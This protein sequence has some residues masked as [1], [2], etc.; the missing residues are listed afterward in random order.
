MKILEN[1]RTNFSKFPTKCV[2]RPNA[3]KSKA[4][5]VKFFGKICKNNA[6]VAIFLRNF[7]KIF[8]NV[9]KIS[10]KWCF[11]SKRAKH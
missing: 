7:L 1:F 3:Q 5:F 2:F 10:N 8:E 4:W 9:L 6:F 11:S